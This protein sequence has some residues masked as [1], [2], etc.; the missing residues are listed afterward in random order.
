M[1]ETTPVRFVRLF[2]CSPKLVFVFREALKMVVFLLV[3]LENHPKMGTLATDRPHWSV[4][5]FCTLK[6]PKRSNKES[7]CAAGAAVHANADSGHVPNAPRPKKKKTLISLLGHPQSS[8]F[9]GVGFPPRPPPQKKNTKNRRPQ[10]PWPCPAETL[11]FRGSRGNGEARPREA[12]QLSEGRGVCLGVG[13]SPEARARVSSATFTLRGQR[14][15][16]FVV[17]V[18]RWHARLPYSLR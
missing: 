13:N 10:M 11:G 7:I 17:V 8:W 5:P 3:F 2:P 1:L 9:L 16:V 12:S 15:S 14:T 4:S 6:S 18:F